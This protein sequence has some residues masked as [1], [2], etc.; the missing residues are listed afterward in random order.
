[1][2]KYNWLLITA[3]HNQRYT[4]V[5]RERERG[6]PAAEVCRQVGKSGKRWEKFWKS[7]KSTE[8]TESRQIEALTYRIQCLSKIS[9]AACTSQIQMR[10]GPNLYE[11]VFF[12]CL[13]NRLNIIQV[14]LVQSVNSCHIPRFNT[15]AL[16][17]KVIK[18]P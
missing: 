11:E 1:M 13:V 8:S 4:R 17:V 12:T 15:L 16:C 2:Y 3:D 6:G 18:N 14:L 10:C 9:R 5:T 7:D